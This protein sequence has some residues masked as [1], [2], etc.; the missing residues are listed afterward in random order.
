MA[1]FSKEIESPTFWSLILG[2]ADT[3]CWTLVGEL[4]LL[5][6]CISGSLTSLFTTS[7]ITF[8]D[9]STIIKLSYCG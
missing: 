5:T 6:V 4:I 3:I 8:G 7:S 2:L 9:W 1:G